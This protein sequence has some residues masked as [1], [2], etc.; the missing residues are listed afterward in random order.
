MFGNLSGLIAVFGGSNVLPHLSLQQTYVTITSNISGG[1][2]S[3]EISSNSYGIKGGGIVCH[4]FGSVCHIF[5]RNPLILRVF[6]A[7]YGPPL[8]GIFGGTCFCKY[9]GGVGQNC[10]HV[11]IALGMNFEKGSHLLRRLV[12]GTLGP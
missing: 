5:C 4:I 9:G 10:F 7:V 8:Y 3:V 6:D 12:R 11:V 2:F 1:F